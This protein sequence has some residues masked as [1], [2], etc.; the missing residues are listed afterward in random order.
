ML[1]KT[2]YLW[3]LLAL[4]AVFAQDRQALLL[5]VAEDFNIDGNS[6]RALRIMFYKKGTDWQ[7]FPSKCENQSCLKTLSKAYPASVDWTIAFDGKNLGKVTGRTRQEFASYAEA[8]RQ[9][10]VN[11][12]IPAIGQKTGDFAGVWDVAVFR[13]LVIISQP[14]FKDPE[15]WKPLP[16]PSALLRRLRAEFR[17]RDPSLCRLNSTDD[18]KNPWKYS[19]TKIQVA[20]A[21]G[22]T[23]GWRLVGLHLDNVRDCGDEEAGDQIPDPWFIVSPQNAIT[24]LDE[25]VMLVDAGDYDNDGKSELLFVINRFNDAGYELFSDDF[26]KRIVF[27]LSAH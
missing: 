3:L 14:Y 2:F 11:G 26:E 19:D 24:F 22:S 8:G 25:G 5:G 20:R 13:P 27:S 10:I 1:K 7:A 9:D 15:S 23:K 4:L 12:K 18:I 17:K 21:Y 6:V 16:L